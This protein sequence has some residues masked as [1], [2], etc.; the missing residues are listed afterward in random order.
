MIVIGSARRGRAEALRVALLPLCLL[1]PPQ[2]PSSG[3]RLWWALAPGRSPSPLPSL[4]FCVFLLA[5]L[6][7]GR[8]VWWKT[9]WQLSVWLLL[10]RW[11]LRRSSQLWSY[12]R[13]M[14]RRL[15]PWRPMTPPRLRP[16]SCLFS[17]GR[18]VVGAEVPVL[19]SSSCRGGTWAPGRETPP[20]GKYHDKTSTTTILNQHQL[21]SGLDLIRDSP[22]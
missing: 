4:L 5:G 21:D 3:S 7:P 12:R 6:F 1:P 10:L 15:T 2:R 14:P 8:R 11:R 16:V 20:A 18:S 22:G 13:L 9:P 19:T 17:W